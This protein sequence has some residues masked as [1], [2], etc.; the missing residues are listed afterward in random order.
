MTCGCANCKKT[1][2][3]KRRQPT[4]AASIMYLLGRSKAPKKKS[5]MTVTKKRV[6]RKK[7]G[8]KFIKNKKVTKVPRRRVKVIGR[9]RKK[10]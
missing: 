1:R 2:C 7:K 5:K 9:K 10:R 4:T 6:Q 3:T 8:G